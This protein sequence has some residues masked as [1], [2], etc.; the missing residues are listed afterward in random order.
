[1]GTKKIDITAEQIENLAQFGLNQHEIAAALGVSRLTII[2]RLE[3]PE[4]R[5]AY[6][7]GKA[8][9]GAFAK[10]LIIESAKKGNTKAQ[11]FLVQNASDWVQKKHV[12]VEGEVTSRHYV[13]EIPAPLPLEAWQ[14]AYGD[15]DDPNTT[16][17]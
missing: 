8:K 7:R 6:E 15:S 5:E 9:L 3:D 17:Q 4:Y 14:I 2:R 13:A 11:L 10:K 12:Q 16:V 1:M